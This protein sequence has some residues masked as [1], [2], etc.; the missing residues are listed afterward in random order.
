MFSNVPPQPVTPSKSSD[1]KK[2]LEQPQNTQD[3]KRKQEYLADNFNNSN[4]ILTGYC[5]QQEEQAQLLD[6]IVYDIPAKWDS[7]TLLGNLSFWGKIVSISTRVHKKYLSARVRLIPNHACIK[8]YNGGEW[9]VG[10]E[11]I[12][13]RWFSASWNLSECKQREK[14]QA[15]ITDILADMTESSL[16]PNCTPSKFLAE[17]GMKSFKIIKESSGQRK[18]IGY[19][20]TW[21]Q[22]SKCISTPQFWNDVSL[23]WCRYSSPKLGFK[24]CPP[25]RFG[26]AGNKNTRQLKPSRQQYI[27]SNSSDNHRRYN[28]HKKKNS[29]LNS[30][31]TYKKNSRS[32][33]NQSNR[34][35][36]NY[37]VV[38]LKALL[39]Q[40]I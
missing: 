15:V 13:V 24:K 38:G 17:S 1:S 20:A 29:S 23:S 26:N 40:F 22:A 11:G 6:L 12:P 18:L 32:K 36:V 28:Q 3:K 31:P 10:L 34:P 19:F 35:V 25:A 8:A 37:L 7:Y 33:S 21:D 39:E 16:F 14:F 2:P 5:P 30:G 4:L 27:N 9:S